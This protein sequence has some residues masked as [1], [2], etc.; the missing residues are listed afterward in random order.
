LGLAHRRGSTFVGTCTALLGL[1]TSGA[2]LGCNLILGNHELTPADAGPD[3]S[4]DSSLDSRFEAS[5]DARADGSIDAAVIVLADAQYSPLGIAVD[6]NYLYWVDQTDES[7]GVGSVQRMA[8]DGGGIATLPG[9]NQPLDIV[10]DPSGTAYWLVNTSTSS[11]LIGQCMV[12][13]ATPAEWSGDASTEAGESPDAGGAACAVYGFY[14]PVRLAITDVYVVIL[15]FN[16]AQNPYAGYTDTMPTQLYNGQAITAAMPQAVAATDT[17]LLYGDGTHLDDVEMTGDSRLGATL[18]A[19]C[20]TTCGSGQ[21]VKDIALDTSPSITAAYW[22]TNEGSVETA[23]YSPPGGD[24]TLLAT[25][26]G[27]PQRMALDS[28]YVYVSVKTSAGGEI[29]AVPRTSTGKV[30]T[31][32]ELACVPFGIAVDANRVYWTCNDDTIRSCAKP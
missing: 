5:D 1:L 3:S 31:L 18:P 29:V 12:R 26:G 11:P 17:I 30:H 7:G 8:F 15:S 20:N 16:G 27:V 9:Q 6:P 2:W 24:S 28:S 21:V 4:S 19:V 14:Q 32:A 13:T 25:V 23:S 10:V 22:A